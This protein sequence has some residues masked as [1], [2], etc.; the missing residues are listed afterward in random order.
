MS[1]P[2]PMRGPEAVSV[3]WG[4]GAQLDALYDLYEVHIDRFMKDPPGPD[5][6]GLAVAEMK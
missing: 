6:D 5:W 1:G 2:Q 4:P 3:G